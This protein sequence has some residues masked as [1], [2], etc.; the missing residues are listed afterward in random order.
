MNY[1]EEN[2]THTEIINKTEVKNE[3]NYIQTKTTF[4]E[5]MK[6]LTQQRKRNN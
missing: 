4:N 6:K 3:E 2:H 1:E 5:G